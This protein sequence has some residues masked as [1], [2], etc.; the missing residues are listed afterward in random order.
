MLFG[1]V[2]AVVHL[3]FLCA[4]HAAVAARQAHGLATGLVDQAVIESLWAAIEANPALEVTVDLDKCEV[5]AGN[6]TAIFEVDD[7]VRWRLMEGLDDIGIT[8]KQGDVIAEFEAKRAAFMP[9]T[10]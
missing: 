9:T 7:Y 5:R 3:E 6:F 1:R 2:V 10:S 4:Y 8:M